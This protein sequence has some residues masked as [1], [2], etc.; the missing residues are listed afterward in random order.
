MA[1]LS[2]FKSIAIAVSLISFGGCSAG[3]DSKIGILG[4][5]FETVATVE[6]TV[7]NSAQIGFEGNVSRATTNDG[8]KFN[9]LVGHSHDGRLE[10]KAEIEESIR[11]Q[12][13]IIADGNKFVLS[14]DT[15]V[16][17]TADTFQWP[18]DYISGELPKSV[19]NSVQELAYLLEPVAGQTQQKLLK[20]EHLVG[21]A[22]LDLLFQFASMIPHFAPMRAKGSIR[23]EHAPGTPAGLK[24]AAVYV[25]QWNFLGSPPDVC[26]NSVITKGRCCPITPVSWYN[27]WGKCTY[28]GGEQYNA[29]TTGTNAHCHGRCGGGCDQFPHCTSTAN[30]STACVMH[31]MTGGAAFWAAGDCIRAVKNCF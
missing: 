20:I 5:N 10:F 3:S 21:S 27:G 11:S 25:G 2:K 6:L 4:E 8:R 23:T 16:D 29:Q 30:Y 28:C 7:E 13:T 15:R 24:D 14:Y 12:V 18:E 22:P 9:S 26:F 19:L 17:V 1:H 31:D